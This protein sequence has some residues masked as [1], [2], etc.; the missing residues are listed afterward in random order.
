MSRIY[1]LTKLGKR[2][3]KESSVDGDELKVLEYLKEN[4]SASDDQLSIVGGE[5][6]ILRGMKNRGLITEL[7]TS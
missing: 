3:Y 4:H 5:R 2:A 1:A 7:T 6:Y